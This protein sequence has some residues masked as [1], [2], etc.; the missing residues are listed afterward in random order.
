M[1]YDFLVFRLSRAIEGPDDLSEDTTTTVGTGEQIKA[2]LSA[3][4]P[5]TQWTFSNGTWWGSYDGV[6]TWYEFQVLVEPSLTFSIRTSHRTDSRGA[7]PK[8]CDSMGVVAF[9]AQL[10]EL[11]G[12]LQPVPVSDPGH[13]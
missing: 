4:F 11:T 7:V 12:C 8:I 6:D 10:C 1:S 2:E 3:L 9:D 13:R 5:S